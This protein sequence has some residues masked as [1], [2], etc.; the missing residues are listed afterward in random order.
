MSYKKKSPTYFKPK[1][2]PYRSI[3]D[4]IN[5]YFD[6]L[7]AKEEGLENF[8]TAYFKHYETEREKRLDDIKDSIFNNATTEIDTILTR[9]VDNAYND[10]PL[11]TYGSITD[12]GQRFNI[13]MSLRPYNEFHCL[14]VAENYETAFEEKFRYVLNSQHGTL[15]SSE[16]SLRR[17]D[18]FTSFSLNV[19]VTKCIDI[20]N[21][22]TLKDFAQIMSEI[23]MD[24]GILNWG[25]S[26]GI[27]RLTSVQ[28]IGE[29]YRTLLDKE[30]LRLPS[31]FNLPSNSQW[32][33][34]F[35]KIAGVQAIK[36]PSVRKTG[37]YNLAVFPDNFEGT[38]SIIKLNSQAAS[39]RP[40]D[41]FLDATNCQ[42][43]KIPKR[44]S[45][46]IVQ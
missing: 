21:Q 41:I 5:E 7:D 14:Y 13:G 27:D 34:Y 25:K 38:A 29:L 45:D 39:V 44:T 24:P 31:N 17:V 10:D 18:D 15:S 40:E 36:Y 3:Y 20:C 37:A 43:K 9:I 33:G 8:F 26:V 2:N 42:L 4:Y 1:N 46:V 16:M 19:G 30:F 11:C 28:T 32:F 12:D 23:K 22:N 35:A 6:R